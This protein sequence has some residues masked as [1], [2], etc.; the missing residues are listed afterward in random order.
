MAQVVKT[1]MHTGTWAL[2]VQHCCIVVMEGIEGAAHTLPRRHQAQV[3]A[4]SLT[5]FS[6]VVG[7]CQVV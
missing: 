7:G 1:S 5:G 6:R 4:L 2:H 3:P